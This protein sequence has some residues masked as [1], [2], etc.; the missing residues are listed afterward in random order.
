MKTTWR[1]LL[2]DVMLDAGESL[3]QVEGMSPKNLDLDREFD[4]GYGSIQGQPFYIWTKNRVYFAVTC[5]GMEWV[6]SVPRNP[7]G[8]QPKHIGAEI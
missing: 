5:E 3:N 7:C 4:S 6:T 8:A 2:K 1:E